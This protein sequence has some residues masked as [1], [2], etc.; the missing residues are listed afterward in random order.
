MLTHGVLDPAGQG[1]GQLQDAM[2]QDVGKDDRLRMVYSEQA[3]WKFGCAAQ[4][5]APNA[6]KEALNAHE[7]IAY[8]PRDTTGPNR[9]EFPACVRHIVL[10]LGE[11]SSRRKSSAFAKP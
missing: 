7:A 8:R 10:K 5:T 6:V 9:H 4:R 1:L 3:G 11:P 2:Q